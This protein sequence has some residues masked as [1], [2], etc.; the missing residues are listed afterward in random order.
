MVEY[1][2]VA[3]G[4]QSLFQDTV[5]AVPAFGWSDWVNLKAEKHQS[6]EPTHLVTAMASFL[7]E[8]IEP[9][10][11]SPHTADGRLSDMQIIYVRKTFM[12]CVSLVTQDLP[13]PVTS[14]ELWMS[15]GTWVRAELLKHDLATMI[16]GP[17][18]TRSSLLV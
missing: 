11:R 16:R 4:C 1:R 3:G 10:F 14:C 2:T 5:L 12:W 8:S 9:C 13:N 15:E 17:L 6:S 7:C 18:P